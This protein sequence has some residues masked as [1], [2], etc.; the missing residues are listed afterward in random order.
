[1][2]N[3]LAD[4]PLFLALAQGRS[5]GEQKSIGTQAAVAIGV[6]T[7]LFWWRPT[8]MRPEFLACWRWWSPVGDGWAGGDC[9][10]SLRGS[11]KTRYGRKG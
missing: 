2:L 7:A 3:P 10:A 11:G 9:P 8:V 4:F 1:M 6:I 5:R